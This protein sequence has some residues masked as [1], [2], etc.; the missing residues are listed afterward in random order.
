MTGSLT[1]Q[2]AL[3]NHT[4]SPIS[5]IHFLTWL[6]KAFTVNKLKN[7]ERLKRNRFSHHKRDKGPVK[8]P[9][10]QQSERDSRMPHETS[11]SLRLIRDGP[12]P[13]RG[14]ATQK[15]GGEAPA[16]IFVC[17]S[18]TRVAAAQEEVMG[19]MISWGS[20]TPHLPDSLPRRI[21]H[22]RLFFSDLA[23]KETFT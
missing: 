21:L 11:N 4:T 13:S 2:I 12:T 20:G 1:S 18:P 7:G 22:H 6:Y 3:P 19:V 16:I 10:M 9:Q 23:V 14:G 17:P 5:L 8:C 15:C